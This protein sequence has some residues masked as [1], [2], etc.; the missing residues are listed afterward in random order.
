[1]IGYGRKIVNMKYDWSEVNIY[2]KWNDNG[3]YG[4]HIKSLIYVFCEKEQNDNWTLKRWL[5]E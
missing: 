4:Y 5:Y 3:H 1:M 2:A